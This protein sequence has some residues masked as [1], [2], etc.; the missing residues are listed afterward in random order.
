MNELF[1]ITK[2]DPSLAPLALWSLVADKQ[3]LQSKSQHI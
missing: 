1:G 2:S 3:A